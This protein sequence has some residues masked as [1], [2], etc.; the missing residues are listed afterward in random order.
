[1]LFLDLD[2]TLI[3]TEDI[4]TPRTIHAIRAAQE[5][6]CTVVVCT[7]R[8]RH[9]VDPI[10]A[11]WEQ[12][13]GYGVYCNGAVI[14]DL[15]TGQTVHRLKLPPDII[16]RAAELAY[17]HDLAPLCY[18]VHVEEDGGESIYTDRILPI[19]PRYLDWY[20]YRIRYSETSF[21]THGTAEALSPVDIG[22]YGSERQ[23]QPLFAAWKREFGSLVNMYACPEP[24]LGME[25]WCAFINHPDADK[26]HAAAW[27]AAQL[28]IPQSETMAIGDQLNDLRLLE[29]VG[30]GVCM[31]NGHEEAKARAGHVTAS[32]SEDGAAQA[33]ER[34]ILRQQ[35]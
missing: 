9:T 34:F 17:Q 7:G 16:R 20:G 25:G 19:H 28:E 29:W 14:C 4:P 1:L 22:V 12:S 21:L 13:G 15:S 31:G 26:V 24:R 2:G 8:N 5:A 6:G 33:I 11:H 18:G 32:L 30:L 35:R 10:T 27:V 23:V 3:G